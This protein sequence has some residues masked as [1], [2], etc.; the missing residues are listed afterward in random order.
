MIMGVAGAGKS[1]AVATW[2]DRGYQ[3]L[4]RDDLGG[5]L[6][7]IAAKLDDRL[8]AGATRVV[9]DNTY[10][11]RAPRADVIAV[12]SKH[13]AKVACRHLD[14]S[15]HDAQIN[16]VLRMLERY[17]ELLDPEGIARLG[18]R[19]PNLVTPTAQLRMHRELEP[20]NLDEGFASVEVVP[21]VREVSTGARGRGVIIAF[22]EVIA[23]VGAVLELRS[24]A[25]VSLAGIPSD[26]PC[27]VVAWRAEAGAAWRDRAQQLVGELA[28]RTGREIDLGLCPHPAGPPVC[29]CRP[30]MPGLWLAFVRRRGLDLANGVMVG[31]GAMSAPML[32][33]LGLVVHRG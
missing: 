28:T 19:D 25:A 9:L 29:W 27:L 6:K 20:P 26:A 3:R 16:V 2:V 10:T 4:N 11:T 5:T 31:R 23:D 1:R 15:V 7:G 24:D 12:A 33:A 14:V 8:A 30:P 21:F 17:G 18:K 13:G 22:D 32:R